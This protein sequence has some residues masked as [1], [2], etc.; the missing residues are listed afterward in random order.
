MALTFIFEFRVYMSKMCFVAA[1]PFLAI[2]H[3]LSLP[4][5]LSDR[6]TVCRIAL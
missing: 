4:F 3:H 1:P 5:I 6:D 2:L